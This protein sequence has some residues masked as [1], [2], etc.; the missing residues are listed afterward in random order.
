MGVGRRRIKMADVVRTNLKLRC[1]GCCRC[2]TGR[3]RSDCA[4]RGTWQ[5]TP[6]SPA[7]E[8]QS[9]PFSPPG[10]GNNKRESYGAASS[11]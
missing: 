8:L 5:A 10:G 2:S 4:V 1:E 7:Y 11:W 6:P 3:Q 9:E